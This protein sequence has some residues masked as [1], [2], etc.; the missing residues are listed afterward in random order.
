MNVMEYL[1][2]QVIQD[3][4][5]LSSF[6]NNWDNSWKDAINQRIAVN[7]DY[8]TSNI[9]DLGDELREVFLT[10]NAGRNQSGVSQAGT[11][12]EALVCWYLNLCLINTNVV[13]IKQKRANVPTPISDALTVMYGASP[14]NTEADLIA[15]VFPFEDEYSSDINDLQDYEI[16]D[17]KILFRRNKFLYLDALNIL[18]DR[19]ANNIDVNV[20]QCKTNWNDNAQIPMLWDMVYSAQGFQNN[21]ISVGVNNYSLDSFNNFSYSFVTVPTTDPE[22]INQ[23]S[24]CVKRVIT[25]S[26]GNYWGKATRHNVASSLKEIFNR[27]MS[28][29]IQPNVRTNLTN[30]LN[31]I[32]TTFSYFNLT[33]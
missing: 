4:F 7:G 5:G 16:F 17:N 32:N 33:D 20:I 27:N 30:S 29:G 3:L 23:D 8:I 25:L 15:I 12:W 11:T 24:V 31:E 19:D 14:S 26:G 18:V 6:K 21:N 10:T 1:R 9:L 2:K 22:G 13:V 28:N